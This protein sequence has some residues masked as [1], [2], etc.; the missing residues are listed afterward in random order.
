MRAAFHPRPPRR[1][2]EGAVHGGHA[3]RGR[4]PRRG[5]WQVPWPVPRPRA[6][7]SF[8]SRRSSSVSARGCRARARGGLAGLGLRGCRRSWRARGSLAFPSRMTPAIEGRDESDISTTPRRGAPGEAPTRP[9]PELAPQRTQRPWSSTSTAPLRRSPVSSA[10]TTRPL[11][12][13]VRQERIDRGER[14]G[15]TSAAR[16]EF[17]RLGRQVTQLTM[18]RE[19]REASDGPLGD[20]GGTVSR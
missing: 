13:H 2:R 15:P 19:L 14:E 4:S 10:R 5:A 17:T 6:R 3:R 12:T 18:E 20:G 16:E 9:L 7:G 11:A 8:N 1:A